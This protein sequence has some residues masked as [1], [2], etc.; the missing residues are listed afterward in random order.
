M[1]FSKDYSDSPADLLL[2]LIHS[3]MG[4]FYE[5]GMRDLALDKLVPL[6]AER[7]INSALDYYYF[8]KYGQESETEWRRVETALAVNETYF[9]RE[10]R[11]I[12]AAV[13]YLL[14]RLFKDN[15]G[16]NIRIWH[17]ACATGEEPYTLV[18]A[19]YEANLVDNIPVEIFASDINSKALAHARAAIYP[20][21]SFRAME[22]RIKEKYFT[23]QDKDRYQ[24]V[25]KI[26]EKV[27]FFHMN[28]LD[29]ERMQRIKSVDIIF[30]RNA[31]IYFS[32]DS[33]KKVIDGFYDILNNPGY[34]F[35]AAAESLLKFGTRFELVEIKGAFGYR[36]TSDE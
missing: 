16:R 12:E 27:E 18:M 11:Q 26:R 10:F 20:K 1:M 28:L 4:L 24:L 17:A 14:P 35:V 19:M 15:M 34:L 13:A 29:L 9:W 25:D 2:D 33:T 7:G 3:R 8:L 30:C 5:N 21:R 22:Q 6:M 32:P 31:F 36:K 23:P